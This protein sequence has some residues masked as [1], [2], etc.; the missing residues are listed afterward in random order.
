MNPIDS[1]RQLLS[2][3]EEK[4]NVLVGQTENLDSYFR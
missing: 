2:A 1:L 3:E 4:T